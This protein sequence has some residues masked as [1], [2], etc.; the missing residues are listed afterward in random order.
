[1][2]GCGVSVRSD[3]WWWVQPVV[4]GKEARSVSQA[5]GSAGRPLWDVRGVRRGPLSD[6]SLVAQAWCRV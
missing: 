2:K 5:A 6:P 1:M 4:P 3:G